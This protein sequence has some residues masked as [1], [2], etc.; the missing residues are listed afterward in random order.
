MGMGMGGTNSI[1]AIPPPPGSTVGGGA[2]GPGNPGAPPSISP[3]PAQPPSPTAM[4]ALHDVNAIVSAVRSLAQ[5]FPAAVPIAKQINDLVQQLQGKIIQSL[6]PT[7]TQA[8][9]V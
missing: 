6:P 3:A 8:P 4:Q 9:P 5:Q 2:G 1:M 7:E